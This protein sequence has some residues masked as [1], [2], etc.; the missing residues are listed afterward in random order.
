MLSWVHCCTF[1]GNACRL[2]PANRAAEKHWSMNT[3]AALRYIG[4]PESSLSQAVQRYDTLYATAYR[5]NSVFRAYR[6]CLPVYPQSTS[7]WPCC[8]PEMRMNFKTTLRLRRCLPHFHILMGADFC[9]SQAQPGGADSIY[10]DVSHR[11]G[12]ASLFVGDTPADS[13]LRVS[14]RRFPFALAGWN[15]AADPGKTGF[16]YLLRQ[17]W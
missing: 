8:R 11:A 12:N 14:P 10:A 7:L 6:R 17:P 5:T 9:R 15:T 4:V 16:R 3:A 1:H 13:K 2:Q